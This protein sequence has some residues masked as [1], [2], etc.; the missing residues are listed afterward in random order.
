MRRFLCNKVIK[1]EH[2]TI[3]TLRKKA[4]GYRLPS[5]IEH[6]DGFNSFFSNLFTLKNFFE[7]KTNYQK[8]CH[9][10]KK[11]KHKSNI[12]KFA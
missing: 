8:F 3:V 7:K 4:K 11:K 6:S 5:I 1:T 2:I 9:E 12:Q 10:N